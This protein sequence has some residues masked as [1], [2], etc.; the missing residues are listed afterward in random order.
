VNLL[1]GEAAGG[2]ET[3]LALMDAQGIDMEVLSINP[4]WYG[5]DPA[6]AADI[7]RVQNEGLAH[8]CAAHPQRFAAFASL[9][10]QDPQRAVAELDYAVRKLGLQGAAIGGHVEGVNFSDRRFDP[11]WAKAEE[12]GAM[13]FLHP[14]ELQIPE[15]DRRLQGNGM[16]GNVIGNPLGTTIALSHLIF[17]GT[18]DRF[19]ALKIC[20][21]HGGGY[22]PS[23]A[24]RSDV[25]CR[26]A[27]CDPAIR[28][29]ATPSEYLRR[30][31]YDSLVFSAEGLRH[32]VA[33]VG[34]SQVMLGTDV[35]YPWQSKPVDHVMMSPIPE[36]EKRAILGL[37]ATREFGFEHISHPAR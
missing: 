1:L 15:L 35:P 29:D 27:P 33:E 37:N 2:I 24:A 34:A 23:Y 4:F 20:S 31:F 16:L 30:M 17:Q 36:A 18:L 22:L 12:L 26:V 9:T 7:V 25:V 28:L 19:P 10:L 32:L 14:T 3:R 8:L 21:A 6:R 5:D 13:L 11:V